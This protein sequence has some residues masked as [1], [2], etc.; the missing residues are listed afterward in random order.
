M[1]FKINL[2]KCIG[3]LAAVLFCSNLYSQQIPNIKHLDEETLDKVKIDLDKDGDMDLIIAGV[4]VKKNQGRVYLVKNTGLRYEKPEFIFSFPSI[5]MKQEIEIIQEGSTTTIV[6]MGTSP[7]GKKDK[8]TAT[9]F[10]GN[11]EGVTI[12][13]ISS[14]SID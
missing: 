13:P 4:F 1:I 10:N 6:A 5:G 3:A 14:D 9:L 7:T 11:F 8:F 12:P 2:I